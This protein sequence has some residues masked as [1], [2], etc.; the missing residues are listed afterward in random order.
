[1]NRRFHLNFIFFSVFLN[2]VSLI[3]YT[4]ANWSMVGVFCDALLRFVFPSCDVRSDEPRYIYTR[5]KR[6]HPKSCHLVRQV[7]GSCHCIVDFGVQSANLVKPARFDFVFI[8]VTCR[9]CQKTYSSGSVSG[10][11]FF[12]VGI[13]IATQMLSF[14]ASK[15]RL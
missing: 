13:L 8:Y 9:S 4:I 12:L 14:S 1:M 5:I 11:F 7:L 15:V 2:L 10:G 3:F 6:S